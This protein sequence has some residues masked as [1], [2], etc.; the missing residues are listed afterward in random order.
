MIRIAKHLALLAVAFLILVGSSSVRADFIIDDFSAPGAVTVPVI[1]LL[2][3]SPLHIETK[4]AAILGGE[5]DLLLEVIGT[6]SLSSF[7][8]EI[9]AGML[10]FSSSSPGTALILQYDAE[11]V[12]AAG[13]PAGLLNNEGLGGVDL[14]ALGYAFGLTFT[15]I[16]GGSSQATD[17]A[18]EVHST[19]GASTF[20]GAIGDSAAPTDYIVPFAGFSDPAVFTGVT[21]IEVRINSG[22]IEDIDF[23]MNSFSVVPE[24]STLLLL[25]SSLLGLLGYVWRRR[26]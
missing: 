4:D 22:G 1:G 21:S 8:G 16:D 18:I 5:R 11:D 20:V 3:P 6:T 19:A 13:P 7:I 17:I 24:P 14:T 25:A 12:D 15:G 10:K 9:G 23:R 26:R 2:D